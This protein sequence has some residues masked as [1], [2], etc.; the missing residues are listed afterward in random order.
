MTKIPDG[1]KLE[2][3][4]LMLSPYENPCHRCSYTN[5][6]CEHSTKIYAGGCL[7]NISDTHDLPKTAVWCK[8]C[9]KNSSVPIAKAPF[10]SRSGFVLH[11]PHCKESYQVYETWYKSKCGYVNSYGEYI[12]PDTNIFQN[13]TKSQQMR[14]EKSQKRI[15]ALMIEIL[16]SKEKYEKMK[17][18]GEKIRKETS[19]RIEEE[20]KEFHQTINQER[21]VRKTSTFNERVKAGEIVYRKKQGCWIEVK[22]GKIVSPF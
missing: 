20:R 13:P 19:Q 6:E 17:E 18:E 15:E 22:T 21:A 11:C 9:Q 2:Q 7:V 8:N 16:G 3:L 14:R 5:D 12:P 1:C 4:Y 10:H